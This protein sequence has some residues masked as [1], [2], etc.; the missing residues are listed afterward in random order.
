[1]SLPTARIALFVLSFV[2]VPS[3]ARTDWPANGM[4]VCDDLARQ[5]GPAIAPDGAGGAYIAWTDLRSPD[6]GIYVQHVTA[7]GV[8]CSPTLIQT[9]SASAELSTKPRFR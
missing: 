9:R 2:I 6:T 3:L 8:T 4:P 5:L 7:W 1:M